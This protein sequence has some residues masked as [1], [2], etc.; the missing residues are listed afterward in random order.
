VLYLSDMGVIVP[1]ILPTSREDLEGKLALLNGIVDSVQIDVVDGT[2]ASPPTW[3][4]VNRSGEFAQ[5]LEDGDALPYL[6]SMHYEI[7]LMVQDVEE[8]IGLWIAA[9]AQRLV[10]H[11]ESTEHLSGIIRELEVKYGHSKDFA[12]GLLSLGLA[13]GNDSDLSL[14]EP[15]TDRIDYVQFMGIAS[16]GK[17][18]QPFDARVLEKIAAFRQK[19]PDMSIQ[20]DGAVSLETAPQLLIAGVDRLVIGS[21]LW[22][23]HDLK[24]EIER[25]KNLVHE[26]GLYS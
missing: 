3:P 7:D 8:V 21:G 1:A 19:H 4:Y 13:I 22:K 12:P 10:V 2:F 25:F 20:V 17:Q 18:G 5:R 23:S 11:A 15:Y 26:H 24:E 14:I 16:I 6:G 9:G